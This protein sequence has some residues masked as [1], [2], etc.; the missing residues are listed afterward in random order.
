MSAWPFS[1]LPCGRLS[2]VEELE[3]VPSANLHRAHRVKRQQT[4]FFNHHAPEARETPNLPLEKYAA[5][6]ELQFTRTHLDAT[7][8]RFDNSLA[9]SRAPAL[10][11]VEPAARNHSLAPPSGERVRER[12]SLHPM[13]VVS[14]CAQFTMPDVL[15]LPPISKHGNVPEIIGKFGGTDQL[16]KAVN[17]LQTLLYAA[18]R[19]GL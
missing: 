9:P 16:R 1:S 3:T 13:V 6:A 15:K 8:M 2:V 5:A 11:S 19:Y 7:T 10:C 17:E 12:G 4:A 18:H 14:R